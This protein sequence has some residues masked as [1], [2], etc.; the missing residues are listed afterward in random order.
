MG[1]AATWF[2]WKRMQPPG[3]SAIASARRPCQ[4]E[5]RIAS[6]PSGRLR[7][8]PKPISWNSSR[9]RLTRN[10]SQAFVF[11]PGT[12]LSLLRSSQRLE[13]ALAP[14]RDRSAY[15]PVCCTT[16]ACL[17]QARAASLLTR[18]IH[19]DSHQGLGTGHSC[20]RMTALPS[21]SGVA[22]GDGVS[23]GPSPAAH[24]IGR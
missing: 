6:G 15:T 13:Q 12:S 1:P 10:G 8:G 2:T 17:L 7:I 18:V 3:A 24:E 14:L 20:S 23:P 4:R 21:I 5:C 9:T 11:D 22:P 16:S 19:E